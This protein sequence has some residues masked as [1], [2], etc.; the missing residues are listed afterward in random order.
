MVSQGRATLRLFLA[1]LVSAA[2]GA[3]VVAPCCG[4]DAPAAP[5]RDEAPVGDQPEGAASTA[6]AAPQTPAATSQPEPPPPR[7]IPLE[8]QPYRIKVLI[9]F[10]N[11]AMLTRRLRADVL[12]RIRSHS[13]TFV[14]EAW[15]IDIQDVS[16]TLGLS[17]RDSIGHATTELVVPYSAEHDKVFLLGVSA[18]GDQFVLAARE[19]DVF[20]AR[21]GPLFSGSAREP[22]Q[23]ARELVVLSA[24]LFSPLA[25]LESGDAKRVTLSIRGGRLPTLNPDA[26]DRQARYKPSFQFVPNGTLFRPMQPVYNEDRT[27]ILGLAPKGWTF[28]VVESRDREFATCMIDSA[29]KNTLPPVSEDANDPQLIVARTAGGYTTLRLVD[30]D[31]KAP[32]PAMDVEVVETIG[33]ASIP[34][35]TTDPEGRIRI[36]PNRTGYPLVKVFVRHGRDTMARLPIMPGAGE[37]P[38][39]AL[40]PDAVRLDIEG[41]VM[42]MQTQIVD[43][44]ARR[45]ILAGNRNQVTQ[46]LEGGAIRKAIE[47][48]DWK[49]AQNLLGQLKASPSGEQMSAKLDAAKEYARSQR[50]EDKWTGKIKRLFGETEDIIK[51][52]FD[53]ELFDEIVG[54]LEDDLKYRMEDAAAE[55]GDAKPEAPPTANKAL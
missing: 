10:S 31:N 41:R 16:E 27:E 45:T 9:S 50:P 25:R 8:L 19:F 29:L 28:Y 4:Q 32:L 23:V 13:A 24:R 3:I 39:L 40:N 20:F 48:K 51:S 7:K 38:D 47:K 1:A 52:Y 34:L 36:P 18:P 12:R 2:F 14:G 55:A 11:D 30:V 37:E 22:T 17:G 21:W 42:A 33:A 26:I 53:P 15:K 46:T 6:P 54:E 49:Q 5:Q 43:Q 44:V 35:G